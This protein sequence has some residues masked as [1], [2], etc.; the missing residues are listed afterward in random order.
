MISAILF[1]LSLVFGFLTLGLGGVWKEEGKDRYGYVGLF[2]IVA[3]VLIAFSAG[4]FS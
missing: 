3:S 4:K 1:I 2:C